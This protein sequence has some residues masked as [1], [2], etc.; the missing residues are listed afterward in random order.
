MISEATALGNDQVTV[1]HATTM[2]R[3]SISFL[4]RSR[5]QLAWLAVV[6]LSCS[7]GEPIEPP[8][9]QWCNSSQYWRYNCRADPSAQA[10]AQWHQLTVSAPTEI[11]IFVQ[12]LDG[13]VTLEAT[14][15]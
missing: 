5:S 6:A 3:R 9:D 13:G 15:R 12:G 14:G 4:W 7:S 11:A 8:V 1:N 10:V 2:T